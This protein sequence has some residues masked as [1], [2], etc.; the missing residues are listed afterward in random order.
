[1]RTFFGG[2]KYDF[3]EDQKSKGAAAESIDA[4]AQG[5]TLASIR[6]CGRRAPEARRFPDLDGPLLF[7]PG[8]AT[9]GKTTGDFHNT[10]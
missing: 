7:F 1:M 8:Y 10:G 5:E 4:G 2:I 6:A 9:P 3:V